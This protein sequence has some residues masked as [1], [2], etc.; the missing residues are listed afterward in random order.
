MHRLPPLLTVL[1]LIFHLT[2]HAQE[3]AREDS[4]PKIRVSLLKEAPVIDPARQAELIT[5]LST[6]QETIYRMRIRDYLQV[7]D[8][9]A[10]IEASLAGEDTQPSDATKL[11][12][13]R[14]LILTNERMFPVI[15][16]V[17]QFQDAEIRRIDLDGDK[18]LI[19]AR[20]H[21]ED[22]AE[23]KVRW[24]L[25]R[26][27]EKW[28]LT[29]FENISVSIRLSSALQM[30]MQAAA[31]KEGLKMENSAKFAQMGI[32]L[33]DGDLDKALSLVKELEAVKLPAVLGEVFLLSKV[34][35][36]SQF[37]DKKEELDK[38]L[39]DLEKIAPTSPVL[40]M[41]RTAF[42]YEAEDYKN[43]VAWG[44]KLGASIGHDEDTWS[45][46][47]DAFIELKEGNELL[48]TAE[49]WA[50]DYPN[51]VEALWT[52]WGALPEDQREARI[53]PLLEQI[54]PAE[55]PLTEF[56][57]N[58]S[59]EEDAAAFKLVLSVMQSRKL[60][61]D[62]VKEYQSE[63]QELLDAQKKASKDKK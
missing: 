22:N 19:I 47:A 57:T 38:A 33:Q 31:S 12:M 25:R 18:A 49:G 36:L 35:V 24:W 54:T 53:K 41:M 11:K 13:K 30:G 43:T 5:W 55:E 42:C 40:L 62:T 26:R 21:D 1:A 39:T 28:M 32:A 10:L 20:V 29:D 16:P 2:S 48:A 51:S 7:V 56:A 6:F 61:P 15:R 4:P 44:R 9:D 17:F 37:D 3:P 50:A 34:A 27:G 23:S 59:V 8:W 14:G 60:P 45:M 63:Y 58:A 46:M 52:L